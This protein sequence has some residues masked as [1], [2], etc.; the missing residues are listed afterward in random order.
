MKIPQRRDS[1]KPARHPL[2]RPIV[3]IPAGLLLAIIALALVAPEFIDWNGYRERISTAVEEKLGRAVAI[4]GSLS[5]TLLPVPQMVAERVHVANIAGAADKD[6]ASVDRMALRLRGLP[7]LGGRF[8]IS[9]L[10]LERPQIHIERLADGRA[11][12][13]FVPTPDVHVHSKAPDAGPQS[14]VS[15]LSGN[16][17]GALEQIELRD[18]MVSLRLPRIGVMTAEGINASATAGGESG[19]FQ[20]RVT[21]HS[22]STPISAQGSIGQL[23][24]KETPVDLALD[25]GDG[26]A[27]LSLGG[28]LTGHDEA[29]VLA[30]RLTI[31]AAHADRVAGLI[32]LANAPSGAIE[33]HGRVA[34]SIQDVAVQNVTFDLPGASLVGYTA[35]NLEG[36]PQ[37]DLKLS[38]PRVD[39]AP[40]SKMQIA[41]QDGGKTAAAAT[42]AAALPAL[43]GLAFKLP[44][45]LGASVDLS[46][47]SIP[48]HGVLIRG[49][50][51]DALLANG[52]VTV[53]QVGATLPG[54]SQVNLFGFVDSSPDGKLNF[55]GSFET[56]T[57]DL[58]S[59]LRWLA[60]DVGAV[61][62]DR[63]GA[64]RFTG[65]LAAAP[66][67]VKLDGAEIRV[68]GTHI[69]TA[70]DLRLPTATAPRPALGASFSIDTLNADAYRPRAI[71]AS[72]PV[73]GTAPTTIPASPSG[74][75]TSLGPLGQ[76]LS[77]FDANI[78][79]HVG[80][81]V[82]RGVTL[83]GLDLDGGLTNGGLTLRS[84]TVADLEG[85]K[86]TMAGKVDDL[87]GTPH[88]DAMKLDVSATDPHVLL[89]AIGVTTPPDNLGA[90]TLSAQIDGDA[91]ALTIQSQGAAAGVN[92]TIGGKITTPLATPSVDLNATLTHPNLAGALRLV[93]VDYRRRAG[94]QPLSAAFHLTGTAQKLSVDDL[95]L[96]IGSITTTGHVG[97]D[98]ADRTHLDIALNAGDVP[99][100]A[101]MGSA[102]QTASAAKPAAPAPQVQKAPPGEPAVP[103]AAPRPNVAVG[104]I[105]D[106]FSHDPIDLTWMRSADASVAIT[107]TAFTWGSVKV[108][109]PSL[110]M[111]LADGK[112]TLDKFT[113]KLWDGDLTA[114]AALDDSGAVS[115]G[116]QLS[117]AQLKQAVLG[118]A[119]LNLAD[120][121]I[122][123]G[124]DLTTTG[125]SPAELMGRLAGSA[126]IDAHDGTLKGFDLK[127]A[128][129]RLKTPNAASL[130][131]LMQ[132]GA[133]GS[134]PFKSLTGT[135]KA[136]GGIF[137]SDDLTLLADGG[138]M[139]AS[140]AVN[141]PA[142]A[143]DAHADL[144]LA[145]APDAPPLVLRLS[146]GL[147]N[148][149]QV[150][151]INP[152]QTW[153]AQRG[154][155]VAK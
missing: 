149:R 128:D 50:R 92:A 91:A 23:D 81:L 59:L 3:A 48:W 65:H 104:G 112:A 68:D 70:V 145:D 32:G 42:P 87:G 89:G 24:S 40:W 131:T 13:R 102:A 69:T 33:L 25:L 153:L 28:T 55:D 57:D 58:R 56:G 124:A 35:L 79:G 7:L 96:A 63:L 123:F 66:D 45:W 75:V 73:S 146:G 17:S 97:I 141:L 38:A 88:F 85:A 51:L 20:F 93:G 8:E 22:G 121:M 27:R 49:A 18:A 10:V 82:T 11:N 86:A 100:D 151:D 61:P 41:A 118:V 31:K 9:S 142:Y 113:A 127:A 143:M 109:N 4:D 83:A 108:N 116:V 19:P 39:F 122:D 30:G 16:G 133:S 90:L 137:T 117:K 76:W 134:T 106:H 155:K 84:L 125:D 135:I 152:L 119:N 150:M 78:R 77:A 136:T 98:L 62:E 52:E 148:P 53:N 74:A 64:A 29:T 2:L 46:A 72:A 47:E 54:N 37:L 105:V 103:Q 130:L 71:A 43:T 101:L 94:N 80:Q 147:S 60:V 132:A 99:L 1:A 15:L 144:H 12:W 110:A 6:F 111:T 126:K 34:A 129:A 138:T 139:K 95:K 5:L 114:S 107:A 44:T 36:D 120:G 26:A 14:D 21:G 154:T 115:G 140:G 67:R